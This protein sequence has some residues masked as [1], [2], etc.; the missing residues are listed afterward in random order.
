[1]STPLRPGD[2]LSAAAVKYANL[3]PFVRGA[4]CIFARVIW[5]VQ[6][7]NNGGGDAI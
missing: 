5:I 1:L 6:L 7:G 4:L 3:Q 2:Y